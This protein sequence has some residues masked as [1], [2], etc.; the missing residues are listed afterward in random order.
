MANLEKKSFARY[1][2]LP[3]ACICVI[4]LFQDFE[5][6]RKPEIIIRLNAIFQLGAIFHQS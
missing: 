2:L 6:I 1:V 3:Y 4:A 5:P